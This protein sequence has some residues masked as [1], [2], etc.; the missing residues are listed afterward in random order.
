MFICKGEVIGMNSYVKDDQRNYYA[1]VIYES[2]INGYTGKRAVSCR[3]SKDYKVGT[4][5]DVADDLR[6]PQVLEIL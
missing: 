2:K 3:V 1:Q 5:V 6:Y 4:K